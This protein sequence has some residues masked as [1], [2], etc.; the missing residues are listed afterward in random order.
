MR[1][2]VDLKLAY[3]I[4]GRPQSEEPSQRYTDVDV[5]IEEAQSGRDRQLIITL[6]EPLEGLAD[7]NQVWVTVNGQVCEGV[8]RFDVGRNRI[9]VTLYRR[10]T[11]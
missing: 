2:I 11:E 8:G 7:F 10:Q 1:T 5:T 9:F 3:A 4:I 6:H